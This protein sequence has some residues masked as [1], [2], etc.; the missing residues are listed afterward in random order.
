[1]RQASGI[2]GL[3]PWTEQILLAFGKDSLRKLHGSPDFAFSTSKVARRDVY[4]ATLGNPRAW[5]QYPNLD[6][7]YVQTLQ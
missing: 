1:M 7:S 4:L 3:Q 6:S 2:P 5:V